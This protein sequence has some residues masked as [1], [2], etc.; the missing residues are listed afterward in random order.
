MPPDLLQRDRSSSSEK[1]RSLPS[2]QTGKEGPTTARGRIGGE[3]VHE[4][5]RWLAL[6]RIRGATADSLKKELSFT[7]A[8]PESSVQ[9]NKN[10]LSNLES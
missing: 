9:R 5:I 4:L 10:P 7:R 2:G 8:V 6:Q 1:N 3:S